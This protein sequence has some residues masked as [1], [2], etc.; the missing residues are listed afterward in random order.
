L[1]REKVSLNP[2]ALST[3]VKV[4]FNGI[5]IRSNEYLYPKVDEMGF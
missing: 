2:K 1:R 3:R 4:Y 5:I